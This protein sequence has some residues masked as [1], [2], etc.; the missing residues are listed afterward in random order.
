MMLNSKKYDRMLI[1]YLFDWIGSDSQYYSL[2]VVC[3]ETQIFAKKIITIG[4]S[5]D[6]V[7]PL[8]SNL[9]QF[10]TKDEWNVNRWTEDDVNRM[11]T[12][13][14]Q[15][16]SGIDLDGC[17]T[18]TYHVLSFGYTIRPILQYTISYAYR[19]HVH[20]LA[21]IMEKDQVLIYRNPEQL[22]FYTRILE[23]LHLRD[24]YKLEEKDHGSIS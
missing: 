12:F 24:F 6:A 8:S 9:K 14:K 15:N 18:L 20:C 22:E 13:V 3:N 2:L 17:D 4:T 19:E 16:Y 7:N 21:L 11:D 1:Y 23:R 10:A 5:A